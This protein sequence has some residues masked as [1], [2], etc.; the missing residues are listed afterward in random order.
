MAIKCITSIFKVNQLEVAYY[1]SEPIPLQNCKET[2]SGFAVLSLKTRRPIALENQWRH[3]KM[4]NFGWFLIKSRYLC[5]SKFSCQCDH[6]LGR[7]GA[8]GHTPNFRIYNHFVLWE[9]ISQTKCCYFTK[10]KRFFQK[11]IFDPNKIWADYATECDAIVTYKKFLMQSF[12]FIRKISKTHF[13]WCFIDSQAKRNRSVS[14][15]RK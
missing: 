7:V 15:G 9:A 1:I 11:K 14:Y 8:R 13:L 4:Q 10:I 2:L 6:R 3:Y 5:I 12:L